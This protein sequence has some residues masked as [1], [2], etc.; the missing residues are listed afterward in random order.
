[1]VQRLNSPGVSA[2]KI[3]IFFFICTVQDAVNVGDPER[4]K[5]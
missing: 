4:L 1:M 2:R 3:Y 5:M